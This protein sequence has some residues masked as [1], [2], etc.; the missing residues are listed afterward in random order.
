MEDIEKIVEKTGCSYKEAK[1]A[2]EKSN[3][4]VLDAIIYI[5]E[6]KST[7]EGKTGELK[8]KIIEAVKKGNVTKIVITHNGETVLN[9]PVNVGIIG[10]IAAPWA[11]IAGAVAAYGFDCEFEII[12]S[13]G[14]S[15]K[16][17]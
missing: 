3:N 14:T 15:E 12:K 17:K 7:S 8:A 5:E 10:T 4:D 2:Y 11:V 6:H 9:I 16:L 13:D 1:E